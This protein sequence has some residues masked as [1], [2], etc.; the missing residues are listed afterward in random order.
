MS[1]GFGLRERA[2]LHFNVADFAVAVERITDSGLRGRPLI[3]AP[4]QAARAVVY[5]MSEEAYGE[6][7]RKGMLLRQATKVCRRA[8]LLAPRITLYQKAMQAFLK[9]LQDYSPLIE[10]GQADGHFFV[11][12]TGTHRLYGPAPDVGW[13]VRRHVR[14]SLGINP[15]WTLGTS[16]LVS[17]VAS[18]V[19]KPVGEYI[20]TAGDEAPFL[21][22]LPIH[23]LPGLSEKELQKLQEFR[24]TTIGALAQLNRRQLMVPFGSRC[25]Y[26]HAA[27]HGV[28][29]SMVWPAIGAENIDYEHY[30]ADDTN[31]QRQIEGVVAMLVSRGGRRLRARRQVARR[32]GIWLRYSDGGHVVRQATC[33]TGTSGD[34]L[35]YKLALTALQRAWTRRTRIR[36]CRLVCDRLQP[37]SPQLSLFSEQEPR[38][39]HQKKVLGAMDILRKRFGHGVIGVGRQFPVDNGAGDSDGL[40]VQ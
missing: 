16:K 5:D 30:F 8:K 26:L 27:S 17:K 36:S 3:I 40:P 12:V 35:L 6:G 2:V 9:E 20:V 11:D 39:I 22:P 18:R 24:L 25:E 32:V 14:T 38:Q 37:E 33:R 4:L 29:D 1:Q 34:F 10:C 21:A 19:V 15:I 7:V 13:R 28:D 23:L 31:D